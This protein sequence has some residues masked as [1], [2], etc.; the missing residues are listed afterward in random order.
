[1][2]TL[3][4]MRHAKSSWTD[5]TLTDFERP[6][7]DRGEADAPRM[8]HFLR[9]HDL[10]PDCILSSTATRAQATAEALAE[11]VDRSDRIRLFDD[12]YHASP[13]TITSVVQEFGGD[14]Q[15]L[16]VVCH[17]PGIEE[18]V[19]TLGGVSERMSTAAIAH[20]EVDTDTWTVLDAE[21]SNL[22]GV[23]RPKEIDT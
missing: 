19:E 6:L 2:R 20:F 23:Y 5:P 4:L 17:N 7:N 3:L 8:G 1:M 9:G 21:R 15:I 13:S 18:L 12:L 22:V 10:T 14:A 16:M 11:A